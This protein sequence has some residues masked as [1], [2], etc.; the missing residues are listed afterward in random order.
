ML[1]FLM[2]QPLRTQRYNWTVAEAHKE[3]ALDKFFAFALQLRLGGPSPKRLRSRSTK[4]SRVSGGPN[5]A[6]NGR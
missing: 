2:T 6:Q 4:T 5:T 3:P 1:R